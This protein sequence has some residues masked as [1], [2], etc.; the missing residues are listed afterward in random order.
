[1]LDTKPSPFGVSWFVYGGFG[2]TQTVRE[3]KRVQRNELYLREPE[4]SA[5]TFAQLL[6][7]FYRRFYTNFDVKH[8]RERTSTFSRYH[9]FLLLPIKRLDF[10][11]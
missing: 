6:T 11:M 9:I 10:V 5:N 7:T 4:C 3:R 1:M 8:R 2:C